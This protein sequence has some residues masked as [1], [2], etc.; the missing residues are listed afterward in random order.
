M[1]PKWGDLLSDT[2]YTDIIFQNGLYFPKRQNTIL[3]IGA[4]DILAISM[5]D[6][7]KPHIVTY[8]LNVI[9]RHRSVKIDDKA[10]N[11]PFNLNG[12]EF[13]P[14]IFKVNKNL[15][16]NFM[17]GNMKQ[18]IRDFIYNS[19]AFDPIYGSFRYPKPNISQDGRLKFEEKFLFNQFFKLYRILDISLSRMNIFYNDIIS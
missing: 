19:F 11:I 1:K 12:Y 5:I 16:F 3:F 17:V 8:D 13:T 15:I 14:E 4:S 2:T 18:H 6:A 10:K 9:D 7:T